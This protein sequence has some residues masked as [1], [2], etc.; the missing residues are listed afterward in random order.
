MTA[1]DENGWQHRA[2][3]EAVAILEANGM[4]RSMSWDDAVSMMAVAW[5]QGVNLGAHDTLRLSEAAFQ[6]LRADLT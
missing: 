3:L 2:R 6:R 1:T 4:H 5:L